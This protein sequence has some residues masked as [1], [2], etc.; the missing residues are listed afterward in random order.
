MRYFRLSLLIILFS[1]QTVNAQSSSDVGGVTS[2]VGCPVGEKG[3]PY[4]KED[5][6]KP[7]KR[8]PTGCNAGESSADCYIRTHGIKF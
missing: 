6:N 1:L 7:E 8:D 2:Q 3:K 4:E 5:L